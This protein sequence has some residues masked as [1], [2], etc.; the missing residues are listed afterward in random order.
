MVFIPAILFSVLGDRIDPEPVQFK[1]DIEF[2]T[3]FE[4]R[5]ERAFGGIPGDDSSN[6]FSRFRPGLTATGDKWLARLQLQYAHN[7]N[8][9]RAKNFS[10]EDF[11]T[12][13]MYFQLND[14]E[15]TWT[16]GRQKIALGDQRLIGPLEWANQA[17]SFDGARYQSGSWDACFFGVGV[18]ANRPLDAK[19]GLVSFKSDLGTTSYIFKS[20]QVG[21][22]DT[23]VHTLDHL[24]KDSDGPTKYE[25]EL[26]LQTGNVGTKDL[27][28]YALHAGMKTPIGRSMQIQLDGNIASGGQSSTHTKS[29]D[30]LYPTNHLYYGSADM[31]GWKNMQEI[32]IGAHYSVDTYS[33]MSLTFHRFWLFDETDSWYG[34]GGS[35]N[36]RPGGTFSDSSGSSGN[37]VGTEINLDFG[38]SFGENGIINTGIA[39]FVPGRFIK[40]Q[41]GGTA[42]TQTWFYF[43]YGVKF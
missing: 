6:L 35:A 4:R 29:F 30:N 8:W 32:A 17:R 18:S 19:V 34:A 39:W 9:T 2:R 14:D 28:A 41:L 43:S 42:K 22:T 27:D 11:E 16:I 31:V 7:L 25:V 5:S 40:N 10:I 36:K 21:V 13:L 26:A 12:S 20:D 33:K 23:R 24:W 37:D 38:K 3:R 15:Q 1:T